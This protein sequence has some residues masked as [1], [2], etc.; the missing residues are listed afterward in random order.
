MEARPPFFGKD[1]SALRAT[2]DYVVTLMDDTESLI[3]D[4]ASEI[5]EIANDLKFTEVMILEGVA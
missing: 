3:S 1:I 2:T 5:E 4:I